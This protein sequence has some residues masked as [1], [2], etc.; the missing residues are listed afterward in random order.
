MQEENKIDHEYLTR[1]DNF[2]HI[3][4]EVY[5]NRQPIL[6][7]H[8]SWIRDIV[9]PDEPYKFTHLVQDISKEDIFKKMSILEVGPNNHMPDDTFIM[10]DRVTRTA[11]A[12]QIIYCLN[13]CDA[14]F[15]TVRLGDVVMKTD[16]SGTCYRVVYLK[17][18]PEPGLYLVRE[19]IEQELVKI[20]DRYTISRHYVITQTH[21]LNYK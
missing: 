12:V 2:I 14:A 20:T 4:L 8:V 1:Q 19:S 11:L 9:Q 10:F 18:I 16:G 21:N 3:T 15:H 7:K 5:A 13:I 17:G 6:F